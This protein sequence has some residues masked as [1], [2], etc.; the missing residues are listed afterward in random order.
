MKVASCKPQSL[1]SLCYHH[2]DLTPFVHHSPTGVH[3][4]TQLEA[5]TGGSAGP[6]G[7]A[8]GRQWR[9]TDPPT[10]PSVTL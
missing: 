8:E 5:Q 1:L 6:I 10:P 7:S 2:G 4:F 3:P 9:L